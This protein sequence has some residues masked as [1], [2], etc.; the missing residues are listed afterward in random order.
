PRVLTDLGGFSGLFSIKDYLADDPV[1]VSGTDSVGTKLKIAFMMNKHD[2]IGIDAVAMCVNDVI[3]CGAR[4]L[5]F[6]DYIGTGRLSPET[7]NEI[8]D[9]VVEGCLQAK[10]ALIGGEMAE[11]PGIYSEGEYDLVG[12][13]VG[14]VDR[15]KII[16]GT[17]IRAGDVILGLPSSGLHSNGFSLV[18][19][20]LFDIKGYQV[21]TQTEDFSCPLG[22]VLLEPTRIYVDVIM[23]LVENFPIHGIAHIT[24]GGLIGNISRIIPLGLTADVQ[25]GNWDIPPI[26]DFIQREGNISED[27]MRT[28]FNLGVGMAVISSPETA[29]GIIERLGRAGQMCFKIGLVR[30]K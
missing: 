29:D 21:S 12:F 23:S 1:L 16:Y 13:C 30:G 20:V 2:T 11:M 19:K 5:F 7:I 26:F 14:I 4:P 17:E 15:K 24:G 10:C 28:V 9:G 27:E 22:D 25:W 18:R 3:T 6:L 8:I